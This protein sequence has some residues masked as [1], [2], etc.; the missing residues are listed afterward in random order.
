MRIERADLHGYRLP[1]RR[2][3]R[4]FNSSEDDAVFVAL[5]LVSEEGACGL[6]EAPVKPTWSGMSPRSLVAVVEDVLLPALRGVDVADVA[7]VRA[8]LRVFPET[9]LAR[10]LVENACATLQAASAGVPLWRHL[11]GEDAVEL[12]WCVTRQAPAAMA[13]EAA[14]QVGAHGFKV[15]KIKGGQGLDVDIEAIRR[16][17][18]AVGDAIVFTVDAN[19]AYPMREAL[20]YVRAIADEGVVV[21]EDPAVLSPGEAFA[22]LVADSPIPI[23]VDSPCASL[24][25]AHR[26]LA[27]G[28][29]ALSVKPGRVGVFE[30]QAIAEAARSAG[31]TVC[32]GMCAESLLGTL[33]SLQSAAALPSPLVPAEQS[34]F[35]MMSDQVASFAIHIRD[36]VMRLPDTPDLADLVDWEKVARLAI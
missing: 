31:A 29:K 27:A 7:A 9:T 6:A 3:V 26:F 1:Y 11:G 2:P 13:E 23:L 28:A 19:G 15:L 4:W 22:R 36:G 18:R 35:L 20:D 34:F 14:E 10:M 30:A 16:I 5:R 32:S 8:A 25:D 33:V 12:S 17:R 24:A 21:A